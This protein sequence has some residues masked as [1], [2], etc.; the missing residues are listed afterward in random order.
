MTHADLEA[1]ASM[2]DT[3]PVMRSW[4]RRAPVLLGTLT[5]A[6]A[7]CAKNAPQDTFKAEGPQA[8]DI[9]NLILPV[10]GI[11]GFVFVFVLG[12]C[13][14]VAIKFRAK[15]QDD[16]DDMPA[17]IHGNI[18][19]ELGWTIVPALILA[20]VA[21]FTV[22][23][24]FRLNED[25]PPDALHVRVVGQQW[26]WE[27]HY[28]LDNDGKF[29]DIV[30][31]NDLVMP[32]NREV[33]LSITSRDVIHSFWVPRLNGK[34]DAVPNRSHPWKLE[35]DRTGEFVGQCTEYCGLSHAQ[36]RIKAIA[37]TASEFDAWAQN[38]QKKATLYDKD[39][40]S[41]AA[42]GQRFFAGQLCASC[43][44]VNGVNDNNFVSAS[45]DDPGRIKDPKLQVSRHAPNLTHLMSRTTFAGAKFDLRKDTPECRKLGV[46]WADTEDGVEKC[47]N[48]G[49]LEAWLRNP[50]AQKAMMSEGYPGR[51]DRRGMPNL[52]LTEDQID[53]LV[54]YLSTLK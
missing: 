43:H 46:T 25:P 21:V 7:S 23:G 53:L 35:A 1:G 32:V 18:P 44:L 26:W 41:L 6:L 13:V 11:A 39:D 37:L 45:G 2:E 31:A 19:L 33:A 10:F 12:G 50:P 17:Q 28:D 14:L 49:D 8:R 51:S 5:L 24:V 42:Q 27:Y 29:D 34:R 15:N 38:M 54:D 40:Q 3:R 22:V 16:Y 4:L 47:L 52:H 20:F 36:M 30:T 48:R 9:K